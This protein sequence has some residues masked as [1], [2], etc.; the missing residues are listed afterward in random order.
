MDA[1]YSVTMYVDS[2]GT[3]MHQI[4]T[5]LFMLLDQGVIDLRL[6]RGQGFTKRRPNRQFLV[7]RVIRHADRQERLIAFDMQDS[8]RIGI[9]H[10]LDVV[11]KYYKRSLDKDATLRDHPKASSKI[12]PFGLNYQ[13]IASTPN[14]ALKRFLLEFITAPYNPLGKKNRFH[15][16]NLIDLFRSDYSIRNSNLPSVDYFY[17]D[18]ALE[19][20]K[21]LF[22]CRLW[23]PEHTAKRN[24]E[25]TEAVNES[26]VALIRNLK[27]YF[28][29]YFVGGLQREPFAERY[30]SDLITDMPAKRKEYLELVRACRITISSPGL[31][32]SIGWKF[33]EYVAL[34]RCVVSNPISAE[35]PGAFELDKNYLVY[36]S[37]DNCM[38][39]CEYLLSNLD[40]CE[41]I[42]MNNEL[43]Y[44]NTLSPD[45]AVIRCLIQAFATDS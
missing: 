42:Q 40:A 25:N 8:T 12:M 35:I 4:Y 19:K 28:G 17:R 13:V 34:G 24:K 5:G 2:N 36:E 32:D 26:R 30:Y 7:A 16:E 23:D 31:I 41:K 6:K 45:Q 43:Y 9:P 11:D 27:K 3:H 39:I 37:A 44:R 33:G 15:V 1:E 22:Q 18:K 21:I 20:D 29:S 14:R 38:T 10:L